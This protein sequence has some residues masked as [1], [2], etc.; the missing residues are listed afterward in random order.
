MKMKRNHLR[1][2]LLAAVLLVLTG[3][4]KPQ[5]YGPQKYESAQDRF[6]AIELSSAKKVYLCPA[7]D[8]LPLECR[9]QLDPGFIPG[10]Y[11][12]DAFEK[13]LNASGINPVRPTFAFDPSFSGLKQA[14]LDNADPSEDAAYLG[15]ELL[16]SRNE[17][18]ALDAKLFSADGNVMF[19]KRAICAMFGVYP[20]DPQEITYMTLRQIL[21]DPEFRK[22]LQP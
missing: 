15:V 19:E 16:W 20:V 22:A 14:I 6:G 13:E 21:S 11:T 7:I 3:C 2:F 8:Q 9:N 12:T 4:A 5:L 10:E 18:W 17:R 1:Y